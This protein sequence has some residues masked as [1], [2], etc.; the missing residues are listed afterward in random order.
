M[1]MQC[2]HPGSMF[3][4]F[5]TMAKLD[6]PQKAGSSCVLQCKHGGA[7]HSTMQAW[8]CECTKFIQ[9]ACHPMLTCSCANIDSSPKPEL[10]DKREERAH[11]SLS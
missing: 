8:G 5:N 10:L 11:S 3:K 9:H 6:S 4:A 7:A 1:R 2:T